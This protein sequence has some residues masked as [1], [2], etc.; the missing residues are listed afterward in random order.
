MSE[1]INNVR[2]RK[3]RILRELNEH[4]KVNVEDLSR[5]FGVSE[6]TIRKDLQAL[7]DK[8]LLTR[9]RGGAIALASIVSADELENMSIQAKIYRNLK[10]KKAIAKFAASLISENETILLDSGSTTLELAKN[11]DQ[12]QHLTIITNDVNIGVELTTRYKRFNVILLGGHIRPDSLSIVGPVAASTLK[13]FYCDK[14]FLGV[15]SFSLEKG[16]TTTNLEEAN[17]NQTMMSVSKSTIA[18]L[19]SSKFNK[20]SFAFI[21]PVSSVDTVITDTNIPDDFKTQLKTMGVKLFIA[22]PNKL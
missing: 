10:E 13:M 11:L 21:A 5:Q 8:N 7:E 22:D 17:V 4:S 18:I 12:F 3:A 14:L 19:D 2:E 15:D 1:I 16:L 9:V 20:R 6:V